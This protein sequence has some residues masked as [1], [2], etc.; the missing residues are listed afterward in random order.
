MLGAGK[1]KMIKGM[2]IVG[3]FVRCVRGLREEKLRRK[4]L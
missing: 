3:K 4:W 2:R 1:E